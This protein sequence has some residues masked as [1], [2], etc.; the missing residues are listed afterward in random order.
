[1][2]STVVNGLGPCSPGLENFLLLFLQ[3]DSL[4]DLYTSIVPAA[5]LY[6]QTLGGPHP[7]LSPSHRTGI[8]WL[9]CSIGLCCSIRSHHLQTLN[10]APLVDNS[11][12]VRLSV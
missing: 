12:F 11:T 2:L 7:W 10:P 6:L 8:N 4:F 1:M 9:R 3:L 5:S